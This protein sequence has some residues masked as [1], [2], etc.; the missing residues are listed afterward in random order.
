MRART[1]LWASIGVLLAAVFLYA[2]LRGVDVRQLGRTLASANPWLVGGC[3]VLTTV[4]LAFRA[5]RWRLLLNAEG[6]VPYATA[7]WATAAGY[8]GN[9]V[10]P[11]RAGELVRTFLITGASGLDT[12]YVLATALAERV[13]DAI[14]LV[15]VASVALMAFPAESGFLS[16][17]A[18][19]FAVAGLIGAFVLVVL[20]RTG[21][22]PHRTVAR[23]PLPPA[24]RRFADTAVDGAIRGLRTFHGG[25]VLSRFLALTAIIWTLDAV[26]A[27]VAGAAIGVALTWH[28]SFL[29]LAAL[30]LASALPS[31]PGYVGIYQFVAVTVLE[32]FGYSRA[33]AIALVVVMQLTSYG[34]NALWGAMGVLRYRRHV[35]EPANAGGAIGR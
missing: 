5:A 1:V 15:L 24:L 32:P 14:V 11:A 8:F 33:S 21:T 20:P 35:R 23:L 7:F 34:V 2:A 28:V 18:R 29:L 17:A 30:G 25:A 27:V 3:C 26:I 10:L 31:S 4:N 6:R 19:P 13:I 9:N 12:A 16:G 22:W